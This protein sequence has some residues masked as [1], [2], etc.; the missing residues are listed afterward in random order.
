MTSQWKLDQ[1]ASPENQSNKK[2]VPYSKK[3]VGVKEA[4]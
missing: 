3:F 4:I 2:R 1:S